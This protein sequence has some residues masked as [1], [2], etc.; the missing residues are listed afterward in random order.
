MSC[1][2]TIAE[3]INYTGISQEMRAP[4]E[5][6]C[7][8]HVSSFL[9]IFLQHLLKLTLTQKIR[10][11][12]VAAAH[13]TGSE[14]CP[15]QAPCWD[16]WAAEGSRDTETDPCPAKPS[17]FHRPSARALPSQHSYPPHCV[18]VLKMSH[19]SLNL[20]NYFLKSIYISG[21]HII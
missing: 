13:S 12:R 18:E 16:N 20:S 5:Q 9:Y 1:C 7:S 11:G 2:I 15:V 4:G 21:T 14:L 6:A 17:R 19:S 3:L 8:G 10:S